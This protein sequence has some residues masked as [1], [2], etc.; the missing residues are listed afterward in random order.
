MIR[1]LLAVLD[2][3]QRKVAYVTLAWMVLDAV[4][5]GIAVSMLVPILV[6]LFDGDT[7]RAI[8]WLAVSAGFAVLALVAHYVQAMR[9]FELAI[10][11]LD[12][13]R[14]RLGEH[15]TRLPLG[16]FSGGTAGRL[17]RIGSSG[18]MSVCQSIAHL[19]QPLV[20]GIATPAVIWVFLVVYEWR[21]ALVVIVAVP[22]LWWCFRFSARALERSDE[23]AHAA[24]TAASSAVLEFARCQQVLRAF[25]RTSG[26]TYAPLEQAIECQHRAGKHQLWMTIPGM[27]LTGLTLQVMFSVVTLLGV[28]LAVRGE[29][30]DVVLVAVLALLARFI[31][32]L[33]MVA[34]LSGG[35]RMARSDLRRVREVLDADLL[36]EPSESEQRIRP[37]MVE[38][39]QVTFSYGAAEVLHGVSLR[40]ERGTVTAIVGASGSGKSTVTRLIARFWDVDGGSVR[41]GGVDVRRQRTEDLMSQIALVFQDV[42]LFDGTLRANVLLGRPEASADEIEEVAR[43]SGV[44]EI[45][46]RLPDGWDTRVGEGGSRLSGGERQRVSIARAL[47]KCAQVVILDEATAA[48]DPAN[49][50]LIR[51]SIAELSRLSTV[52]VVAHTPAMI[53][54]AD[55]IVVLDNGHIVEQGTRE[56]LLHSG[57]AFAEMFREREQIASW[58]LAGSGS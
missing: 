3:A 15:V 25:G 6:A 24:G 53:M 1:D 26:D 4:L 29:V 31:G 10:A 9:N 57:G 35:L 13:L 38:L 39:D 33:A 54:L 42:Y 11:I 32:P 8:M 20:A 28:W 56:R 14:D 51:R 41:V 55:Q 27:A 52:I 17:S 43:L 44:D 40:A 45:I 2:P 16:W 5:Q 58:R 18:V 36:P 47:L 49:E 30:D 19:L 23:A 12:T 7:S 22:I 37:G 48:L 34:E 21:L 50:F 46:A